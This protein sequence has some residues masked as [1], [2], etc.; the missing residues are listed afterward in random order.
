MLAL[1]WGGGGRGGVH[2]ALPGCTLP[3]PQG[4]KTRRKEDR[5]E[6]FGMCNRESAAACLYGLPWGSSDTFWEGLGRVQQTRALPQP[7]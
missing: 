5:G 2:E 3:P 6:L 4:A 7:A 1:A